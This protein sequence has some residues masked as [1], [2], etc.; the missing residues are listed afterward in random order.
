MNVDSVV[1]K[2]VLEMRSIVSAINFKF[3]AYKDYVN[4]IKSSVVSFFK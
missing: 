2:L 4:F 3:V 1:I